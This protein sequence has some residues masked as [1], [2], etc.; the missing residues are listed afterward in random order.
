MMFGLYNPCTCK[1]RYMN[2][3]HH[4][5]CPMFVQKAAADVAPVIMG[6]CTCG[7]QAV[8]ELC[9]DWCDSRKPAG[10]GV[11]SQPSQNQSRV[12][13]IANVNRAQAT[14]D[15]SSSV[16]GGDCLK[17]V[18]LSSLENIHGASAHISVGDAV[19]YK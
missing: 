13:Y 3:P 12:Y 5:G 4:L 15:L 10:S 9:S 18:P 19:R 14:A 1:G 17:N 7:T 11:A 2:D 16:R 8:G 6:K